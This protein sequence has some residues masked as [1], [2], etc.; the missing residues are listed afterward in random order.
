MTIKITYNVF[1]KLSK[2]PSSNHNLQTT[3]TS[4][5]FLITIIS[6]TTGTPLSRTPIRKRQF[7]TPVSNVHSDMTPCR[8]TSKHQKIIT[9]SSQPTLENSDACISLMKEYET[10]QSLGKST[11]SVGGGFERPKM[12]TPGVTSSIPKDQK[13]ATPSRVPSAS[14][15]LPLNS[16]NCLKS[17][18]MFYTKNNANEQSTSAPR[19][20]T[21]HPKVCWSESP[22]ETKSS[23][24]TCNTA[25]NNLGNSTPVRVSRD[26]NLSGIQVLDETPA[27]KNQQKDAKQVISSI[28]IY[29]TFKIPCK[30]QI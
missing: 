28:N 16:N 26:L 20:A 15:F 19:K 5:I 11:N 18:A 13:L 30:L 12:A 4:D 22:V 24:L 9:T 27:D 29:C 17:P 21:P 25:H 14:P 2:L 6:V 23:S 7:N 8:S 3:E 10:T 1:D